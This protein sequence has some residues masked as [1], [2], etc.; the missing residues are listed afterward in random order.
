ME[1][2]I[3]LRKLNEIQHR[4]AKREIPTYNVSGRFPY[5]QHRHDNEVH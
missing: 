5:L 2:R 3:H 1:Y 4:K